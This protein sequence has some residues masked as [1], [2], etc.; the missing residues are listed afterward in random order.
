M[1]QLLIASIAVL[2]AAAFLPQSAVARDGYG[3]RQRIVIHPQTRYEPGEPG[4][5]YGYAPGVYVEGP[6][7]ILYGPYPF[8]RYAV[9]AN[10]RW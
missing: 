8:N 3:A 1:K 5:I 6:N 2:T 7:R 9:E 10:P 4:A